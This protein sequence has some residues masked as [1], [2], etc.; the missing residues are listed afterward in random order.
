MK[1]TFQLLLVSMAM[2]LQPS[3]HAADEGVRSPNLGVKYKDTTD[4]PLCLDLYYPAAAKP[5]AG[6]P[7]VVYTHGGGW[8]NGNRSIGERGLKRMAV[9]ALSSAG[10]CVASVDYRLCTRDGKVVMRDCV[11]DAKDALRYLAKNAAARSLDPRRICTFGDSAGAH[12]AQMV[13]LSPTASFPGDPAL[14]HADFRVLAGVSWYGP[15]DFEKTELFTKPGE[16]EARDRFGD[17]ILK[18]DEGAEEKL[19]AYREISPVN[20]LRADGPALLMMQGEMDPTMP[21]H[22]ARYME[23]RASAAKAPVE[24]VIVKNASHCWNESGGAMSPSVGEIVDKT[25]TFIE[26]HLD[27]RPA[28]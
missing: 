12:I 23:E 16:T 6:Y 22:H 3:L 1:T 21:V 20:Y 17:R 26:G 24:V 27:R 5:G 7:L 28:R 19:T 4:G 9:N 8:A 15:S 10:F 13:L 2:M 11:I 14:A 18:G 25:V